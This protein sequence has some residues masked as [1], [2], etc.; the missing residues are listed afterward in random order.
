MK[1][2]L[3]SLRAPL[4]PPIGHLP[5][6]GLDLEAESREFRMAMIAEAPATGRT[7]PPRQAPHA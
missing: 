7:P 2:N 1:S 5:K 4:G 3:L 6:H